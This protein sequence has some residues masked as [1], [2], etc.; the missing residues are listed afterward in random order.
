MPTHRRPAPLGMMR[1]WQARLA[2]ALQGPQPLEDALA[3]ARLAAMSR[4]LNASQAYEVC[5]AFLRTVDVEGVWR[6]D[7]PRAVALLEVMDRIVGYCSASQVI[8]FSAD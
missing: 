3:M 1:W 4:Q 7:D 6:E 2:A 5:E 8:A